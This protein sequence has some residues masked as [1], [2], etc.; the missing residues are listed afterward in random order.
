MKNTMQSSVK[1]KAKKTKASLLD[2]G[3]IVFDQ[4][5]KAILSP[6][7]SLR[8][9]PGEGILDSI[10]Q[11][12]EKRHIAGLMRVNH[13]GEICAQALYQGQSLAAK[14]QQ[15]KK[16]L[17]KT[18]NEEKEHLAWT[19]R[20][21]KELNSHTSLLNPIW[22]VGSLV[23]GVSA[24]LFGDRLNLGFLEETENQVCV[25]LASH[26]TKLPKKDKKSRAIIAQMILD[27]KKHALLAKKFGAKPLPLFIKKTMGKVAKIMTTSSYYL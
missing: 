11:L 14:N 24:G 17:Q 8:S 4:A 22:Y 3:I 2:H 1:R 7:N 5:L 13:C 25:H 19:K 27:E 10:N 20:R 23:I 16:V 12:S 9:Y 6:P 15:N 26:L 18:L 21:I